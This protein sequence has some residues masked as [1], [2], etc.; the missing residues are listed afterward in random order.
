MAWGNS[1]DVPW[2]ST[3]FRICGDAACLSTPAPL[4]AMVYFAWAIH[5]S[6]SG[7]LHPLSPLPRSLFSREPPGRFTLLLSF[8]CLLKSPFISGVPWWLQGLRT[9]CGH[10]CGSDYCRGLGSILG[11]GTSACHG[12]AVPIPAKKKNLLLFFSITSTLLVS[13]L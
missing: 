12:R 3:A 1:Y 8:S 13:Q 9:R 2:F 4:A 10:C 11:P 5:S 7:R 6:T